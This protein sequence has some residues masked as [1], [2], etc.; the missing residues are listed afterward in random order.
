MYDVAVIGAGPAVA[1]LA[2]LIGKSR[3][4]LVIERRDLL[5]QKQDTIT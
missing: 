3:K 5:E 2:R 4:V 1:T